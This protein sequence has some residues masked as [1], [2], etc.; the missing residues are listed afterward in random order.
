MA[1]ACR[2]AAD[3]DVTADRVGALWRHRK[4]DRSFVSDGGL[5]LPTGGPATLRGTPITH[6]VAYA[7]AF[8]LPTSRRV[9]V[10]DRALRYLSQSRVTAPMNATVRNCVPTS[11]P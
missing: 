8:V 11:Q 3:R 4:H 5:G 9:D 7:S 10:A 1:T 6:Q 2:P